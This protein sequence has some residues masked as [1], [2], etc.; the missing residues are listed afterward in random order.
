MENI[1]KIEK[2][3]LTNF[4]VKKIIKLKIILNLFNV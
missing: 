3:D 2:L 4:Y 1:K